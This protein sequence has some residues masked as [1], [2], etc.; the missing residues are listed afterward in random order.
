M[1]ATIAK[2][3]RK[4]YVTDYLQGLSEQDL[5]EIAAFHLSKDVECISYPRA[6]RWAE[7]LTDNEI[8]DIYEQLNL[9]V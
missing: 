8:A 1:T 6:W 5:R 3:E 4:W 7:S 9:T 2:L